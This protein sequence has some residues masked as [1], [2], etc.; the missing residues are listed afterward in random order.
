MVFNRAIHFCKKIPTVAA[1]EE[2][3]YLEIQRKSTLSDVF[4]AN[5][6]SASLFTASVNRGLTFAPDLS[7]KGDNYIYFIYVFGKV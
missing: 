3:P 4:I 2:Y 7:Q 5:H 1:E 6:F